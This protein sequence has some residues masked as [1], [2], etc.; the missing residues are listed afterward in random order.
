MEKNMK[1]GIVVSEFNYDINQMMLERAEEHANFLG[2]EVE[3]VLRV[4]GVFDMPLGIKKL[5]EKENIDG[6]VTLGT[7]I[8]GETK[9][10]E[11]VM[12]HAARKITDLELEYDKPVSLGITG[13]GMSRMQA[14]ERI[15]R[16]KN[17]VEAAVKMYERT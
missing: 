5:L 15:E 12:S 14:E 10:D 2:A 3:E 13:P 9:H 1:L 6:V 16:A 7:V 17:A 8:K 4:P 11:T